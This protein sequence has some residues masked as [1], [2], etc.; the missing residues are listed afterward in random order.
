[1][2]T[3]R[4]TISKAGP[5]FSVL[6]EVALDDVSFNSLGSLSSNNENVFRGLVKALHWGAL[7]QKV[8]V[9]REGDGGVLY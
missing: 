8:K 7:S 9:L 1:M 6:V 4:L 3:A 5:T 2:A